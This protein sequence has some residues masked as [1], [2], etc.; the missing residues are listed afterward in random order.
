MRVA[1]IAAHM[2][3]SRDDEA[4]GLIPVA[5]S[6]S[7]SQVACLMTRLIGDRVTPTWIAFRDFRRVL[8]KANSERKK[9]S[10]TGRKS[11]AQICPAWLCRKVAHVYP[12]G[13]CE[14]TVLI[15]F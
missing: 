11:H 5:K 8:K 10:V 7:P 3:T 13:C 4:Y 15:Y 14:Q 9:R 12:R 6:E 2:Y 1:R